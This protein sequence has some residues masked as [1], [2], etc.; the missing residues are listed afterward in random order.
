MNVLSRI[1]P[2]AVLV[3]LLMS[4][5]SCSQDPIV[6]EQETREPDVIFL[7]TPQSVVDQML[8]LAEVDSED[9]VY[10][11]GCGDGIIVVSAA[12]RGAKAIGYDI[13]PNRIRDT[14]ANINKHNV[15][16]RAQVFQEDIF[17]LDLSDASVVTLYLLPSL[18]EKL[19]PQLQKLK[20]GSKI[21]SHDFAMAGVK[22]TK[23]VTVPG[24]IREHT[25]YLWEAPIT[26][27]GEED[28]TD[29]P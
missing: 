25:V 19:I 11:L 21:V 23:V 24:P 15:G 6:A 27:E 1:V 2:L 14:Q 18:N 7:P 10:D 5:S 12:K 20:P 22:P 17:T 29:N 9:L 26:V 13:D 8:E 3:C 4:T 16:D 28:S